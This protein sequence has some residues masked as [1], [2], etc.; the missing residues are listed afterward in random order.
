MNVMLNRLDPNVPDPVESRRRAAGRLVRIAY[1]ISVFGVLAFFVVYFGSPLVFLTGP[2]TVSSPRHVVSLPYTVQISDISV[3]PGDEVTA[4]EKL[5]Q[6]RSPDVDNIIATYMRS[7]ADIAGRQ[8]ELRVRARAAK[9]SLEAAR[10]YQKLTEDAVDQLT[11]ST[12]GSLTFRVEISRERALARKGVA[13]QEAE[14]AEAAVQLA[15]LGEFDNQLRNRL[16]DVERNFAEG[17]VTA[18]IAGIVATSLAHVGQSLVAGTPIAEILHPTDVYVDWYIP[19]E[20]LVNPK[21]GNE[22][23][24]LFGNWRLSGKIAEILPISDVYAGASTRFARERTATQ[25]ARIR[26][27]PGT[28][29]PAL[30]STVYVHMHYFD[31]TARVA[32]VLVRLFGLSP[33]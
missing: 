27:N 32:D 7:L 8:A 29:P 28:Q 9:D 18:P 23:S 3:V 2:G 22:V 16:K 33:A 31:F 17:R 30:N 12:A 26:F 14:I 13:S 15:Y 4:G 6:V 19:N 1:A 25:I 24:V 10:A 21:V 20:R 5:A 11:T